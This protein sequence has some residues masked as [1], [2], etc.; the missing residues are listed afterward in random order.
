MI[1]KLCGIENNKM[2]QA[3][4]LILNDKRIRKVA[5]SD[6]TTDFNMVSLIEPKGRYYIS[7]D[8]RDFFMDEYCTYIS[9]EE[10]PMVGL[11]EKPETYIPVLVDVDIKV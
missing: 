7:R 10:N 8:V 3:I 4:R 2:S 6:V 1:P 11:A 9:K 5:D